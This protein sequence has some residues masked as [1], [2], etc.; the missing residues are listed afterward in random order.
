MLRVAVDCSGIG[1]AVELGTSLVPRRA[2]GR[3]MPRRF[4]AFVRAGY[5]NR[6]RLSS[7]GSWRSTDE[8]IP[9]EAAILAAATHPAG[10]VEVSTWG[11]DEAP[12]GPR[13]RRARSPARGAA[14][15]RPRPELRRHDDRP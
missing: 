10:G 1:Q 12:G 5:G 3:R 11:V 8:L 4:G 6:T 2:Q 13:H 9:R 14:D 15:L 7:L